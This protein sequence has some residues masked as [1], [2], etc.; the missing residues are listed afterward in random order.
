MSTVSVCTYYYRVFGLSGS[1]YSGQ[2]HHGEMHGQ[3]LFRTA[4]GA[5]YEGTWVHSKKEGTSMTSLSQ[6][7]S[8]HSQEMELAWGKGLDTS[9]EDYHFRLGGPGKS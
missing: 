3:G 7:F 5:Q 1:T 9:Q 8:S 6:G 2:F 4:S